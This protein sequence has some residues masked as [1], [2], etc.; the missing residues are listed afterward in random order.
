M[1][2][3]GSSLLAKAANAGLRLPML[4]PHQYSGHQGNVRGRQPSLFHK[5]IGIRTVS[6]LSTAE[7]TDDS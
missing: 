4:L 5:L 1:P 3:E 2:R 7:R 6:D